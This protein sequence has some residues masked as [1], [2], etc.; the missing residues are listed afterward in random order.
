MAGS[1]LDRGEGVCYAKTAIIVRVDADWAFE[2]SYDCGCDVPD[3]SWKSSAVC[4]AE[5]EEIGPGIPR[6]AQGLQGVFRIILE[7]VEEMFGIV[8]H[9]AAMLFEVRHRVGDHG[10]I[11]LGRDI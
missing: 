2:L 8:E 11:F 1:G 9:L 3:F 4:V 5:H 6:G 7:A 10:K